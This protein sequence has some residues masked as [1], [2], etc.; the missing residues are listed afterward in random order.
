V[1]DRYLNARRGPTVPPGSAA[2]SVPVIARFVLLDGSE[3]WRPA[4]RVRHVDGLVLVRV[5]AVT[6]QQEYT[7]LAEDDVTTAI[8]PASGLN[9]RDGSGR[10]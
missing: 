8:R 6:Y 3:E 7:W 4:V 2:E 10:P 5:G 1:D 9:V